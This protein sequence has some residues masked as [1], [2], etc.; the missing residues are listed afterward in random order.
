MLGSSQ[1]RA[2]AV[3]STAFSPSS[4][5]WV[6]SV[7]AAARMGP[8]WSEGARA[9]PTVPAGFKTARANNGSHTDGA[10]LGKNKASPLLGWKSPG[11]GTCSPCP[12]PPPP[13]SWRG[14]KSREG[15]AGA[16]RVL[17]A[18]PARHARSPAPAA[19]PASEPGARLKKFKTFLGRVWEMRPHEA[20]YKEIT[21]RWQGCK[22]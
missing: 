18:S 2:G 11:A 10:R 4:S 16:A 12:T 6:L 13:S 8:V 9:E 19:C 20:P 7:T 21:S 22:A 14:Q 3:T 17:G 5:A 1:W 15:F